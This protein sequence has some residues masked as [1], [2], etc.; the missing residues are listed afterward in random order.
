MSKITKAE[1]LANEVV[2]LERTVQANELA[3]QQNEQFVAWLQ[4]QKEAKQKIADYWAKIEKQ[5]LDKGIKNIKGD[6]GSIT[7]AERNNFAIDEAVLPR[8]YFKRVPDTTKINTMF[9]LENKLPAGVTRSVTKYIT[10][11]IKPVVAIEGGK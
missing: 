4:A 2:A 5:M 8:S 11:K 10:K 9:K 1:Q 3:M 7:I 6:W